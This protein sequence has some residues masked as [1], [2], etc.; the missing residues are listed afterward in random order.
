MPLMPVALRGL[1]DRCLWRRQA[2]PGLACVAISVLFSSLC[3]RIGINPQSL[4][5]HIGINPQSLCGHI[6]II[7]QSLC[8]HIG[9]IPQFPGIRGNSPYSPLGNRVLSAAVRC[10]FVGPFRNHSDG[11]NHF[12][13]FVG[14]P[15]DGPNHFGPSEMSVFHLAL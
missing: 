12:S 6:G 15:S 14:L 3:S 10:C 2:R 11:P 5:V 8:G 9:V 4:Y 13:C 1:T 7:P